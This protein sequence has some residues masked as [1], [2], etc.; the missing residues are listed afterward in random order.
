[1]A[2]LAGAPASA[3]TTGS[4]WSQ[5]GGGAARHASNP[6]EH[7]LGRSNVSAL[8]LQ[9]GVFVGDCA[10]GMVRPIVSG[11]VVYTENHVTGGG[12]IEAWDEQTGAFRW[13]TQAFSPTNNFAVSD[14]VVVA[15]DF[16]TANLYGF[17]T[18]DGSL[19][20]TAAAGN[21][22]VQPVIGNGVVYVDHGF[23]QALDLHTGAI[24]WNG[25]GI[26]TDGHSGP[27]VWHN[28]VFQ[29]DTNGYIQAFDTGDG[30]QLWSTPCNGTA[31]DGAI[32]RSP[33][34]LD[35][36][37]YDGAN[38]A[39]DAISGTPVWPN[40]SRLSVTSDATGGSR[41]FTGYR[42]G[43]TN[44]QFVRAEA[45]D[46]KTGTTLWH[47]DMLIGSLWSQPLG[48]GP[49]VANGVVYFT[50][51]SASTDINA[52]TTV[53]RAYST[54]TGRELWHS[55]QFN[56]VIWGISVAD[57]RLWAMIG[58]DVRSFAAA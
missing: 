8:R 48:Q 35:G 37:V 27:A 54:K 26:G 23:I 45:V 34:V 29:Y 18:A 12:A 7:V 32:D 10:C 52:P 30:H 39:I 49:V 1:M 51:A 31:S 46:P 3:L 57:G 11:G 28:E 6:G 16:T 21:S 33:M 53:I 43:N 36:V 24:I 4:D 22:D 38:C 20:W 25:P 47:H 13:A 56:G 9:S 5:N 19:L 40:T 14:G 50:D 2:L 15:S 41:V 17:S 58:T 42:F 44:G 55:K